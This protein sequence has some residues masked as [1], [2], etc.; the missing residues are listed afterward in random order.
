MCAPQPA[1][2]HVVILGGGFAGLEAARALAHAPCRVTLIDRRNHH[3]FQPLLYQ[4]A[5]AALTPPD[6]AW[7]I[8]TLLRRQPNLSVRMDEVIGVDPAAREV[9]LRT[10]KVGYDRL[11]VATGST[12]AYFGHDAWAELAP[13]LKTIKDAVAIRSRLLSAFER[14]E[15][16]DDPVARRALTTFVV[17]G[18][19]PTGV[20]MAGA[21][22]DLARDALPE[23]FRTVAAREARVILV[24]AA[25]R[26]LGGF[27]EGLARYATRALAERGVEV[28]TNAPVQAITPRAICFGDEEIEVGLVVWAAGVTASPAAA[29][30]GVEADKGGRIAVGPDLQ[31][32]AW[33]E[34]FIVGDLA[35][36][37][38]AAGVQPPGLAPAAKQMGAH[39]GRTI[40]AELSGAPAPRRFR[41][42]HQGDLAT[43]G[44]RDAIVRRGRWSITG[45]PAWVFW[46]LVHVYFLIGARNRIAV[47]FTWAWNYVTFTRRARLIT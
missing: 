36:V 45:Y 15:A 16:T 11:V 6:I 44:R 30:L 20:E 23:D 31:L 9:C 41:Y 14:A 42:R 26:I 38:D 40:A 46:S 33:P 2:P 24:E 13:G 35:A 47:A 21:I 18:G 4:V 19:G 43:I 17:V 5:T 22:A 39:A 10:G 37:T 34:I 7:P 25:P 29:W 28:R 8:R 12:H 3:C 1:S 32:R 27:P